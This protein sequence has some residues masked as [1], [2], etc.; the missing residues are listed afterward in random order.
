MKLFNNH[1]LIVA[2]VTFAPADA[3]APSAEFLLMYSLQKKF[4]I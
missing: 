2:P 3:M 4:D 1:V